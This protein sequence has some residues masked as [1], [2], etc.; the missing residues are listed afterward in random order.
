[1]TRTQHRGNQRRTDPQV[2]R[3]ARLRTMQRIGKGALMLCMIV[4]TA[5]VGLWLNQRWSVKQWTIDAEP[6]IKSAIEQQLQTMA[7][8]DFLATRPDLL[9]RQWLER[10]PD[11]ADVQVT[12]ILPDR[13][14]IRARARVP[15]AL[16]QDEQS[17]LHL[18]DQA[19]DAYRLLSRGES[20]DLPLLRM[21]E[22]QLADASRILSVLAEHDRGSI[23]ALSEISAGNGFWHLYFARGVSWLIP[24]AD[25]DVA[26]DQIISFLKQPRWKGGKW[27][28]DARV[29]SRWFVRPARHGGV[30]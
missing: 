25:E 27:R 14:D 29:A 13:L 9:R 26:I 5:T 15:V 1:M 30:I 7:A 20:P 16:W 2:Q 18:F 11:M 8:R 28:V 6:A 19:G 3:A 23:R 12:R 24:Q 21:T 22:P 17:R 10:I 4:A